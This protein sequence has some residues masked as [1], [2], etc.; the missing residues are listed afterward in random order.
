MYDK[1]ADAGLSRRGWN[2]I[3]FTNRDGLRLYARHYPAPGSP[4]R[5]LVCLA[6]LTRNARD[7][8]D[9][10]VSLSD[11]RGHRREVFALD[12]RGRGQSQFDSNW[13]NYTLLSEMLDVIDFMTVMG[14]HDA[15][16]IGTSRGG[17]IAL[18]MAAL[19]PTTMGAVILNDI[20]PVIEREGLARIIGYVGRIPLPDS[21]D[22]AAHLV[23][24]L[25]EKH[26]PAVPEQQWEDIARQW[27]ND[28]NGNPAPSYD[29]ELS[30]AISVMD[31][32]VPALWPQFS[33]LAR[34]PL[35]VLRG[36]HSDI[37][38]AAT[39]EEMRRRHPDITTHVVSGQ[40]HAPLLK[41]AQTMSTINGFLIST[42]ERDQ[43]ANPERTGPGI[44]AYA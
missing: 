13:R 12:Y 16:L 19:R 28:E 27:F 3:Y 36:Q 5:P 23:K 38:S 41:D 40:G 1:A 26:F 25:N 44:R 20:G 18:I 9:L 39:V 30:K 37:L 7:F 10:A 17:L 11:P 33:A 24:T 32:P 22:A 14:L 31:G 4:R 2:D 34:L 6:G 8:H 29:P 43:R 42:D 15:A 35:M 21:W